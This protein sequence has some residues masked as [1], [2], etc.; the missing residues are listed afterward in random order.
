MSCVNNLCRGCVYKLDKLCTNGDRDDDKF[1]CY[2]DTASFLN[3]QY[4]RPL[5]VWLSSESGKRSQL[6]TTEQAT[7]ILNVSARTLGCML[8]NIGAAKLANGRWLYVKDDVVAVASERSGRKEPRKVLKLMYY[9]DKVRAEGK[10]VFTRTML[11]DM[12]GCTLQKARKFFNDLD[13][14]IVKYNKSKLKGT[15]WERSYLQGV[16]LFNKRT[17]GER[18][19]ND[20]Y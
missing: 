3:Q 18:S 10:L 8:G 1:T 12:S 20:W 6:I 14:E 16:R 19:E 17:H 4:D 11:R 13:G 9:F 15:Q 2:R 5:D 7:A